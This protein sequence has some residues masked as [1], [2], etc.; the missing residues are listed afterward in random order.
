ML[1]YFV[2]LFFAAVG[3]VTVF[4]IVDSWKKASRLFRS[5]MRE[6]EILGQTWPEV[7][8][9]S[10]PQSSRKLLRLYIPRQILAGAVP[11]APQV[12]AVHRAGRKRAE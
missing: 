3:I 6:R 11:F 8:N 9:G 12:R 7:T 4:T 2:S 5:L 10:S 1:Q